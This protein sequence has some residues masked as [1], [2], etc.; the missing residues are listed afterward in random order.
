M[1]R[2]LLAASPSFTDEVL[3]NDTL[4]FMLQRQPSYELHCIT[5]K[6]FT[7]MCTARNAKVMVRD[8]FMHGG[9][10]TTEAYKEIL[11]L[12]IDGAIIF[13]DGETKPESMLINKCKELNIRTKVVTYESHKQ[14]LKRAI[15]EAKA[16]PK[17]KKIAVPLTKEQKQR[18]YDAHKE[19]FQA[20]YPTAY[21]DGHYA[22]PK[23]LPINSGSR[24][25]TFI[26][27]FLVWSGWSAT[28][29]RASGR[30]VNGVYIP[31]GTKK[32]TFDITATI[33]GRSVKIETKHG[34]DKPSPDQLKMQER[35]RSAGAVAEVVYSI[36]NFFELYDK[37]LNDEI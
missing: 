34:S 24:M 27:N 31:G 2:I 7:K 35:E 30:Q 17:R 22:L 8:F 28:V 21:K 6:I 18:Y 15:Q 13:W 14:A 36:G 19:W 25:D 11:K 12:C 26:V 4:D 9:G 29:V 37:I 10:A 32:G 33:K 5:Q 16:E 1:F 23:I 3:F 20:Q